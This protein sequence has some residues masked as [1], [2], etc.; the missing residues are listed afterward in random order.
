MSVDTI[1][2]DARPALKWLAMATVMI[3]FMSAILAS[4]MIN[5][6]IPDIMGT[7]GVGQDVAHWMSTGF[8]SAMTVAM[9]LNAFLAG[10]LGPQLTY[11]LAIAVFTAASVIGMVATSI[12]LVIFARIAQGACAGLLQPLAITVIY[13]AFPPEERGKAMGILSMGIVL[14][15]ALGPTV[16]GLIVDEF[17]W[18]PV[19]VAS[20]PFMAIGALMAMRWMPR[21]AIGAENRP[22]NWISFALVTA[23]VAA[24]LT[25]LSNSHRLGWDSALVVGCLLICALSTLAFIAWEAT[26]RNPLLQVRLFTDRNFL[27]MSIIG[28]IFGAGMFA[29]FYLIPLF[30]RTVQ[31]VDATTAGLILMPGGLVLVA[32]FPISGILAQRMP[33]Q[34][35]I[36]AG[37][38][39]FGV[40]TVAM[41]VADT[42]TS[43][44]M[45][46][47]LSTVGRLGLGV[48]M[49]S[50]QLHGLRSLSP[51][52]LAYGA[53]TMN[54]LRQ[55]GGALGTN[56]SAIILETRAE[57][58]REVLL[59]T[60]TAHNPATAEWLRRVGEL[61]D[62][63]G[64][65]G[66][67]RLPA[68]FGYLVRTM[69]AQ[70]NTLSYQ[71]AFAMLGMLFFVA[72]IPA[73]FLKGGTAQRR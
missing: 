19:F 54:F 59:T 67:E 56:A 55:L 30:V 51:A 29:S 31:G 26:S 39:I 5:V 41:A 23:A 70:A 58:H 15:P 72:L 42:N 69:L 61:L 66:I 6:A 25:G 28:F 1:G 62:Q 8:L 47:F 2:A 9:L 32:L 53:G 13:P 71:D 38:I 16:G 18:R 10:R 45:V 27:L 43:F 4:T 33:A 21:Y 52:M 73:A 60:Q 57:T 46:A 34:A 11:L 17:G 63:A 68:T 65:A 48:A 14:G 35:T 44:A 36:G 3:G 50:M 20:L 64:V 37:L 7:F 12:D 24:I 49:P 40:G 22:F